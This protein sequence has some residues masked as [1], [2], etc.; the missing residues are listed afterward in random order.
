MGN[1]LKQLIGF[2]GETMGWKLRQYLGEIH[3]LHI[4]KPIPIIF[5]DPITEGFRNPL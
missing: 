1:L 2:L 4:R 3:R 5:N